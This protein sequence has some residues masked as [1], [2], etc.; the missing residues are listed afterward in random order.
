MQ[1]SFSVLPRRSIRPAL[2]LLLLIFVF[3]FQSSPPQLFTLRLRSSV[4]FSRLSR[5]VFAD[6]TRCFH[7]QSSSSLASLCLRQQS[8]SSRCLRYIFALLTRYFSCQSLSQLAS[9][10]PPALTVRLAFSVLSFFF[11]VFLFCFVFFCFYLYENKF[12]Q[13]TG[14]TRK[15][16]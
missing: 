9:F 16:P 8:R 11:F 1:D 10:A 4:C 12:V 2:L 5:Y 6:L 13:R 7:C 15:Q 14:H 3:A